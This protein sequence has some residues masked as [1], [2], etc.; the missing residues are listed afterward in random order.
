M[1]AKEKFAKGV[2]VLQ[3]SWGGDIY[4]VELRNGDYFFL[5]LNEGQALDSLRRGER[6]RVGDMGRTFI[7]R[8]HGRGA[9]AHE[10]I[11]E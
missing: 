5:S 2:P 9:M 6:L 3:I 7:L 1:S 4:R 8:R 10:K 11:T